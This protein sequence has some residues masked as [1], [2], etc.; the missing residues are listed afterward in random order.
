M[1]YSGAKGTMTRRFNEQVQHGLV[2]KISS[3]WRLE[4]VSLSRSLIE[5]VGDLICDSYDLI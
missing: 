3:R 2:S 4:A 5:I 1:L